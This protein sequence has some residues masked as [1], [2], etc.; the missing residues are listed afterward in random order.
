MNF[1]LVNPNYRS[2]PATMEDAA[3]VTALLNLCA[4]EI[5]GKDE[6]TV[7][8]LQN[9]WTIEGFDLTRHTVM[10]LNETDQLI[11]YADVW[12]LTPPYSRILSWVRVHPEYRGLGIGAS[13]NHWV[14]EK[15]QELSQKADEG[16]QVVLNYFVNQKDQSA[17]DLL[18][19]L[20]NRPV[21]YSWMM[22][23]DLTQPIQTDS[24]PDGF[25]MRV[26]EPTEYEAVYKLDR[27]CFKDHW[28]YIE[29]PFA[30]G[31]KVFQ[32][33]MIDEPFYAPG[34]WFV[35][36]HEGKLVGLCLNSPASAY[37]PD[38]G[39]VHLLG[40][41]SEYRK[42]GLGK[43]LLTHSFTAMKKGG[44]SKAGLSVDSESLTGATRLY[45]NAGMEAKEI[46]VRFEKVIR[47]GKDLRTRTINE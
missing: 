46:Y 41:K 22:E 17:C 36:E 28:G 33:Q 2:R 1:E 26:A 34:M 12:G 14:E 10:V 31:F 13:L 29:T 32:N 20:G 19:G 43:V 40:V 6:F 8:E 45:Q 5:S 16:L 21:R 7:E 9:D 30:E 23:I 44:C 15:A 4:Q 18:T 3:Q 25:V 38:Y 37:G 35:I 27:D 11:G 24:L 39:W 47:E 42:L